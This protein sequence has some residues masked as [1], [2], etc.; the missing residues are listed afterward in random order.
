M[1]KR[2]LLFAAVLFAAVLVYTSCEKDDDET[3][4][5]SIV[6]TP[7]DTAIAH[8]KGALQYSCVI[9]YKSG[10]S[11]DGTTHVMWGSS[12]ANTATISNAAGTKGLATT[13]GSGITVITA[14]LEGVT[15]A[16][17]LEV[18]GVRAQAINNYINNYLGSELTSAL[19]WTG[20]NY[21][22]CIAGDISQDAHN[23]VLQRINYFRSMCGLSDNVTFNAS[24]TG[25]CQECALMMKANNALSHNPPPTWLCYTA[26]GAYAAGGSNIA[27]GIHSV[28]AVTGYIEDPGAN[29]TA[30]GHRAWILLPELLAMGDGS[31]DNTNAIMWK[32]NLGTIP[33]TKKFVAYPPDGYIPATLVFDRWHFQ[34]FEAGFGSATVTM[35]DENGNNVNLNI[36]N[37]LSGYKPD[38]RIVWEPSGINTSS[39]ADVTYTVTVSGITNAPQ[40]TYTYDVIIFK[41]PTA[42]TAYEKIKEQKIP[43]EIR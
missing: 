18:L 28:N 36:I 11:I 2:F 24:Q 13:V 33:A 31:T 29:N 27:W 22:A 34:M 17:T 39:A 5:A 9:N 35:K 32:D 20:T 41:P 23:K 19:G 4:I 40:D 8:Q 42:K 30:V 14:S 15:G 16:A 43:F 3:N 21:P 7:A 26:D 1:K 6:V 37:R 38:N 12:D 25:P 10:Q